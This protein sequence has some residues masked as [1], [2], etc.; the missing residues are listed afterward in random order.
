MNQA[1][2]IVLHASPIVQGVL[3]LLLAM[4][5]ASWA[6]IFAKWRQFAHADRADRA[7]LEGFAQAEE[8]RALDA[9][10]RAHADSALAAA[11]AAALAELARQPV[12]ESP[13]VALAAVERA[14]RLALS[15]G[16]EAL[17]RRV[18]MLATVGA[19]APFVGL[20]GTVWGIM[21]TFRSIGMTRQ[22]TLATV[23]PGI[24]EA[25]V[26]TAVGLFAAIPAVIAYNRFASWAARRE[27]EGE[28]F[29]AGA[30]NLLTRRRQGEA[31]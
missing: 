5:L 14:M 8:L 12:R 9:L 22:A 21:H 19:T 15:R 4:S 3:A 18:P 20:F 26:A 23:A 30:L 7:F 28:R 6:V 2:T 11:L 17:W 10:A 13:Q 16:A 1:W 25:L 29:A 24:A 27:N 31:A